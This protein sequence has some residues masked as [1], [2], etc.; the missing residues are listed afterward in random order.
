MPIYVLR[1][2][3]W[4]LGFETFFADRQEFFLSLSRHGFRDVLS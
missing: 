2:L 4:R 1:F 3:F